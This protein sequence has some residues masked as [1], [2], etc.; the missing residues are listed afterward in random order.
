MGLLHAADWKGNWIGTSGDSACP[1]LRHEFL[2]SGKIKRATAYVFGFG[3]YE[4]HLNGA[5]VGDN[6]LAPV[7][8]NYNKSLYYDTYDVTSLGL[9]RYAVLGRSGRLWSSVVPDQ[10]SLFAILHA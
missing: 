5:K 1:L 9:N 7:N 6:V 10:V 4:L 2:V 3:F 8:S